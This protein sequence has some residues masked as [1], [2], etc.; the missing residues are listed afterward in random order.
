MVE[1]KNNLRFLPSEF[2]CI[3]HCTLC[4]IAE[5]G[6]VCIIAGTLGYLEN[7]WGL[8]LCR[9]L[10]DGLELLHIIE[11]ERRNSIATLD[12]LGEHLSGVHKT[13][14]FVRYHNDIK[15]ILKQFCHSSS[16]ADAKGRLTEK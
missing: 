13:D 2:L 10:D 15:I 8:G 6:L 7:N 9:S 16:A 1:V 14:F 11:V 4:H 3:L 12:S 5:K